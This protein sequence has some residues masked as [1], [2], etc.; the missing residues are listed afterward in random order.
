MRANYLANWNGQGFSG[1]YDI[2]ENKTF[3][4][5]NNLQEIDKEQQIFEVSIWG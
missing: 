5:T 1:V 4:F 2:E 3:T